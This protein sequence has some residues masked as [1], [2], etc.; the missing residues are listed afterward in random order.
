MALTSIAQG[1]TKFI[2]TIF[3]SRFKH[4][5]QLKKFGA[6]IAILN[7]NTA[8]VTGKTS[9]LHNADVY[10]T[11]LRGGAGALIASDASFICWITL[12]L[13]TFIKQIKQNNLKI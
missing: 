11:D 5:A 13:I 6:N 7:Q 10:A 8:V 12:V 3:E 4:I 2:E 9:G 1:K